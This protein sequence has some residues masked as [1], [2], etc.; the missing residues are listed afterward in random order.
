MEGGPIQPDPFVRY[1]ELNP[2]RAGMVAAPADYRWSS[3]HANALGHREA[4][5]RPHPAWVALGTDSDA[6]RRAYHELVASGIPEDQRDALA[7]HTQQQKPWGSDRFRA[8]I[9]ALSG[10]ALEV[11]P[12]GRPPRVKGNPT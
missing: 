9:E 5:L 7:I 11:R 6:R 8:Q 4:R 10:R 1:I 12:V 2:V 3:Y